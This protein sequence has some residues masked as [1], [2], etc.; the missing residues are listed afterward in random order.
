VFLKGLPILQQLKP[1]RH[2]GLP[3][4]YISCSIAQHTKIDAKEKLTNTPMRQ[5]APWRC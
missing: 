3:Q 5:F 1:Q 4:S 2:S